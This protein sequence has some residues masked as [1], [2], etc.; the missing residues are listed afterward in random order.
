MSLTLRPWQDTALNKALNWFN[1]NKSNNNN[2]F[3][4]N[5]A[6]GS[7]KTICASVIAPGIVD[8]TAG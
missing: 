6:P 1:S 2:K 8:T 3:L 7:G 4:I 5:A